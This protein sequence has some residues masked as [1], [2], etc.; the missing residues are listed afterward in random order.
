VTLSDLIEEALDRTKDDVSGHL[1]S[2]ATMARYAN[3]AVLEACERSKILRD[4][5]SSLC[6][7]AFTTNIDGTYKADYVLDP[8]IRMIERMTLRSTGLVLHQTTEHEMASRYGSQWKTRTGAVRRF[9][10]HGQAIRVYNIPDAADTLDME[11]FRRPLAT[12]LMSLTTKTVG[13]IIPAQYH[14]DLVYWML[15]RYYSTRDA[16]L[17]AVAGDALTNLTLFE[18][19]FGKRPSARMDR[20]NTDMPP[21]QQN[22]PRVGAR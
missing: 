22:M 20:I 12:E 6:A 3:D 5:T 1:V 15:Y 16:E 13:P 10:R 17:M 7:I 2:D 9:I 11:V 18:S 19:R 8:S 21:Y 4:T 14:M